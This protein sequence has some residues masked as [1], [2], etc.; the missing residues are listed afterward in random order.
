MTSSPTTRFD[1]FVQADPVWP[2]HPNRSE[3]P[4]IKLKK[5]KRKRKEE[6]KRK[7]VLTKFDFDFDFDFDQKIKFSKRACSTQFFEY[8]PILRSVSS[9]EARKLCKLSNS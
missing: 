3:P 5:K 2:V 4:E 1:P 8:I 9:F 6:K 7:G